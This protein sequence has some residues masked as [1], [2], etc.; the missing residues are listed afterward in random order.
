M[1]AWQAYV[2]AWTQL[3]AT[4]CT[5]PLT[6]RSSV[7]FNATIQTSLA[8]AV[9]EIIDKG[10]IYEGKGCTWQEHPRRL[11][12]RLHIKPTLLN[13]S[14]ARHTPHESDQIRQWRLRELQGKQHQLR[15]ETPILHSL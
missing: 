2:A 1:V 13:S 4:K 15:R 10:L 11:G 5:F 6:S 7:V 12:H 3:Q 14:Y 8:N 9:F